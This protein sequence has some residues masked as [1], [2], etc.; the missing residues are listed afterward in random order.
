MEKKMM[1]R[2]VFPMLAAAALAAAAIGPSA[3]SAS[4]Q[5]PAGSSEAAPIYGIKMPEGYRD[6]SMVSVASVGDPIKDLRV[7]LGNASAMNTLRSDNR[8]FPDGTII[9]RLAYRQTASELNN[10]VF[11]V[12]AAKQGLP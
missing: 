8:P 4:G 9:A 5:A 12:A 7:K 10:A 11:R 6:W 1:N 3:L 2:F